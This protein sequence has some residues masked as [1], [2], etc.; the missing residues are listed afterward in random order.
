MINDPN[1]YS[2]TPIP[3]SLLLE[4][5]FRHFSC[6][7]VGWACLPTN[8]EMSI[9]AGRHARPTVWSLFPGLYSL[10][11]IPWS[12]F[13]GPYSLV[14]DPNGL[15]P[16]IRLIQSTWVMA[17]SVSAPTVACSMELSCSSGTI[18]RTATFPRPAIWPGL[19]PMD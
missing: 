9:S 6:S 3:W 15:D 11:S 19:V 7:F 14:P 8:F 18:A 10:V 2:L 5:N 1:P 17:N 4:T 13:P 16:Y 12:L